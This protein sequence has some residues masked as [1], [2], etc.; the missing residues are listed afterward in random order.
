MAKKQVLESISSFKLLFESSPVAIAVSRLSDGCYIEANEA[1]LKL[2]AY[3]RAEV[4]GHSSLEL[5][6]WNRPEE[7]AAV[8]AQ[9]QASGQS[10]NFAHE[11]R[12]RS[13]ETGHALVSARQVELDGTPCLI[14]FITEINELDESQRAL[15]QR[16]RDQQAIFEHMHNG[17]AHCRVFFEH[18]QL[19]DVLFL[20]VNKAFEKL[21]GLSSVSGK[22]VSEVIPE[23]RSLAPVLLEVMGRVASTGRPEKFENYVATLRKWYSI[24]A[25]S[26]QH[27]EFVAI[28]EEITEQKGTEA[29]VKSGK[30]KI[31]AVLSS[32][33]DAVFITD[34]EGRFLEFNDAAVTFHRFLSR[35]KAARTLVEYPAFMEVFAMDGT[36]IPLEQWAVSRAL[37]GESATDVE[38]R[39][40][41][42]DTGESWIGSYN[43]APMRDANGEIIGS[44][45]TGRDVTRAKEAE[46]AL[47]QESAKNVAILRNASD[48]IHILDEAG[49]LTEASD[50][51]CSMLGYAR[52]ELIGQHVSMWDAEHSQPKLT[53]LLRQQLDNVVRSRFE[54]RHRRKDGSVFDVE[55]TGMPLVIEGMRLLFNSSR[56]IT[57]RKRYE[58]STADYLEKL[59]ETERQFRGMI[60]QNPIGIYVTVDDHI[61]YANSRLCDILEMKEADLIGM[62]SLEFIGQSEAIRRKVVEARQQLHTGTQSHPLD[63]PFRR[64]DGKNVLLRFHGMSGTWN[65][66]H[67]IVAMVE[68]ITERQ[69]AEE[70]IAA[71]VLQLEGAMQETL[72]AVSNMVEMRDPY[73]AG[74]ERRVGIVAADIAR[75]MGWTEDRCESL[76][77]IGL[78]HDIG[79][80]AI[81]AETLTKPTRLTPIEYEIVKT[82]VEQGYQILKDVHFPLPIADIIRQHHERMDGSG[83]PQHLKGDAILPEARVLAVADVLESMSSHRPYR[84]ALGLEAAMAEIEQ[85][86][87]LWFDPEVVDALVRLVREKAYRL[88]E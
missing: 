14:D 4:I 36:P 76:K 35:E 17:V 44:V 6:L 33:G 65:G 8:V 38:V 48:G 70:K 37:R 82:H 53:R 58:K 78:V 67:A 10:H 41:R 47:K 84:P 22:R 77:L 39:L 52:D 72:Q 34:T 74:H 24:S 40:R 1:F 42:R 43:F 31:E 73:T 12:T 7:R 66:R 88:P 28:F 83:Y 57:E 87:T 56:D 5:G 60:E 81:P 18:G 63:A 19:V 49:N 23:I 27:D 29:K 55:V 59:S 50:S 21:T 13:G 9:I 68:D 32:M 16:L 69:R 62:D 20:S 3:S 45:V 2:H 64:E 30:A 86:R 75:E 71:Y 26:L 61:V 80:I 46:Q 25:F 54:T 11:Y 51:F 15:V 85:H 79:K